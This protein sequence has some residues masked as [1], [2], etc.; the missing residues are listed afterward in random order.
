MVKLGH[1]YENDKSCFRIYAPQKK[2]LAIEI[3]GNKKTIP[4]TKQDDGFWI[5]SCERLPEGTLYLINIENNK[6]IIING[7]SSL[8]HGTLDMSLYST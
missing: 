1:Y 8:F 3:D 2:S 6:T 5:G 4:L 7:S